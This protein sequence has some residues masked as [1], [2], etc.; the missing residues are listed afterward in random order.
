MRKVFVHDELHSTVI[1]SDGRE[2][3]LK[4]LYELPA[5]IAESEFPYVE[6]S[7][8]NPEAYRPRFFQFRGEWYDTAEGFDALSTYRGFKR[9]FGGWH[10]I[11][12]E[13]AYS[14][15]LIR[16]PHSDENDWDSVVVAYT[17]W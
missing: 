8:E 7:E 10:A 5:G 14:A 11:Q 1:K 4:A 13:S 6:Y 12:T 16:Y 3:E 17:H 15:V 9:D 2:R